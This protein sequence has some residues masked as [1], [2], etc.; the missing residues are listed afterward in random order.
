MDILKAE[1]ERKRKL[2]QEKALVKDGKKFF[3]REELIRQEEE[4]YWSKQRKDS[5]PAPEHQG[6][7]QQPAT[8]AAASASTSATSSTT[9]A[10]AE[11]AATASKPEAEVMMKRK[12]VIKRLRERSQPILL[13]GESEAESFKRLR[14]LEIQEPEVNRGLRNDFQEAMGKVEQAML[15]KMFASECESGSGSSASGGEAKEGRKA[16][17]VEVQAIDTDI[18]K[19]K[20]MAKELGRHG[21]TYKDSDGSRN[22]Q[23]R[24]DA[25]LVYTFLRFLLLQW[26]TK[27]NARPE[28]EKASMKGR[29]ASAT[30]TQ[31]T[32]YLRPLFKQLKTAKIG[33]DILRHLV[34]ITRCLLE[35]EY[36]RANDCYLQMAIGNAPWPIGVT[37]VGIHARTGREKIFA[38]NIAHV[39]NDE[40][41]RKYIQ[42]LKRLMTQAQYFFPTDPSKCVEF[43][44]LAS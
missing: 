18:E 2:L 21:T 29:I 28:Q 12:E 11:A 7:D 37:M 15:K 5:T 10:A 40:T 4:E 34:N 31:T 9:P 36:I 8:S 24:Q 25:Q 42:A 19:I 23:K 32:G 43:N 35:R 26:G 1:I 13:F 30:Y 33:C 38:Q 20:E 39:L 27:L 41:Q 17:D 3:K 44:A 6:N 22:Q 14:Q 16:H